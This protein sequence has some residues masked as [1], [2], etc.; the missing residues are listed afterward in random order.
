[1]VVDNKKP[2]GKE[3]KKIQTE[4]HVPDTPLP[5]KLVEMLCRSDTPLKEE[6]HELLQLLQVPAVWDFILEAL[7]EAKELHKN[8]ID[9]YFEDREK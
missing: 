5:S 8:E 7:S 9:N 4:H 6:Y 1:M 3:E 2:F